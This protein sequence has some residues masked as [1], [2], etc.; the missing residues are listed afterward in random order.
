LYR[1]AE[2][3]YE[4]VLVLLLILMFVQLFKNWN[5]SWPI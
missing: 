2:E 5:V 1:K 3:I 4:M